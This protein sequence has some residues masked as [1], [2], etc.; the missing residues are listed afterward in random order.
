MRWTFTPGIA[1]IRSA[2]VIRGHRKHQ[3][4]G[5]ARDACVRKNAIRAREPATVCNNPNAI[6]RNDEPCNGQRRAT[7]RENVR[8]NEFEVQNMR[9]W[10]C[11]SRVDL[12][13]P[14]PNAPTAAPPF[15]AV[16]S[17]VTMMMVFAQFN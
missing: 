6:T 1:L 2:P 7:L 10:G 17:C 15:A 9:V 16:L 11:E 3:R 5:V 8:E 12:P 14:P 4:N 13:I